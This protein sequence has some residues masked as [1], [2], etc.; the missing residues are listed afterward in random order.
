MSRWLPPAASSH[1]GQI[2][3]LL[4]LVHGLMLLL[5]VG[6]GLYFMWVLVRF[7]QG[8]QPHAQPTGATGRLA[9]TTEILVVIAEAVL[10][11]VFALPLWFQR[12]SAQPDAA[13]TLTVRV[14]AE[15]FAWTM[16]YPGADGRFGESR[17]GLITDSNPIGLDR[18]SPF[19]ADDLVVP[20]QLHLPV[21]RPVVIQ[22]SSKDV[23]HSFGVAAMRVKQDVVPGLFTPVWF[24]PI[25]PGRYEIACSQLCGLG[26]YRMR[27]FLNIKSDAD[28]RAFLAEESKGLK[29]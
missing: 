5:F 3:F 28:Y 22:L 26:H 20:G 23:I 8:R 7:R 19:G 10:L 12:T 2:D 15:Q 18:A 6:W 17:P 1:A 13:D 11:V 27:G 16:H 21:G 14:I 9:L 25:T 4:L 24:T 29:P